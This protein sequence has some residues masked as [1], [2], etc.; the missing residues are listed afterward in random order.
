M[1]YIYANGKSIYQPMDNSLSLISPKLTLEMG[2]AGSLQFQ[3]PP[4]NKYYNA[5]NQLTTVVTVELDDVEIFRGRVLTNNRSFNKVRTIYCEGNLAYLVDSVQKGEKFEGKAH[6]LFRKII[7]AHN[8]RVEA[9][10]RFTVGTINIENR[11][12][13]L[14]GKSDDIQDAETGKFDY[15]QIALNSIADEWQTSFDYIESCLIDYI[16][17]YLRTRTQNGTTYIDLIT[18]YGST[19][20]Q[21]IEFGKNMLDFTEEVSA[22]D[23]FTVLIPLGD[24]NLTIESVNNG[25]DELV[26]ADAVARYGRIVKTH[27]F[28]GVTEPST[29]LENGQRYLASNV[30]IP[31]TITV[32]AVDF[33]LVDRNISGIYLGDKVHVNSAPHGMLEYLTCTRIGY[34]MENPANNT[35]TFGTPRQSLTERYRKDKK[36]VE[37]SG[38]KGGSA[39][40]GTAEN[41]ADEAQKKID[42]F[43]DAWINVNPEAGHIDLGTLYEKYSNDRTILKNQVG[44]DLDAPSGQLNIKNL[45][46]ELDEATN[47]ITKQAA[48]IDL[49]NDETG[50]KIDLVASWA[51]E[52]EDLEASHYASLTVRADEN[53]S[54]IEGKADKFLVESIQ[55][56]LNATKQELTETRDVLTKTCGIIMDTSGANANINIS[57]LKSQVDADGK[58]VQET[59]TKI[60]AVSSSLQSLVTL[61]AKHHAEQGDKIAAVEVKADKNASAITLKADTTTVNSKISTINSKITTINSD[62][63]QINADVEGIRKLIADEIEATKGDISW[64]KTKTLTSDVGVYAPYIRASKQM[65]VEGKTVATESYV[66]TTLANYATKSWVE[67]K[68]YMTSLPSAISVTSVKASEKMTIGVQLVATQY[69]CMTTKKFATQD[70][71]LDQLANYSKTTHS[72]AWSA[73]T[74]KPSSFT[75][76]K[77]RHSISFS[78]ANGHTHQYQRTSGGTKYTTTGVSTNATHSVSTNTGYYPA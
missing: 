75:P 71:V 3:I 60:D 55:T 14:A 44:I 51:R 76:T 62:I 78:I 28:D 45:R 65:T 64:M 7:A 31:A 74:G 66:T 73:I 57:T 21:E 72:H 24:E 25:S 4:S 54:A 30:N 70:W 63:V 42:E 38:S 56:V 20:V 5:L 50:A 48:R 37:K 33:H 32:K 41:V 2:K 11:D 17:G 27:V 29:L 69:W 59:S 23:I 46:E 39:G 52:I 22:E 15:R 6:D 77:H 16:G 49:I 10:K 12:V 53:E 34:D 8:A 36:K 1:F 68:G 43:F 58:L 19:A 35:Y 13:L 9:G 40:G 61:E 67:E 18:D 26:D 47:A